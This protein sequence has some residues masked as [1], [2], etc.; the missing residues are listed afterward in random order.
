MITPETQKAI[1]ELVAE[2]A[3]V[4]GQRYIKVFDKDHQNRKRRRRETFIV[5]HG[6]R[7][8][9]YKSKLTKKDRKRIAASKKRNR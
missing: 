9:T 4:A 6:L 3:F 7:S 5:E 8:I 1:D 2:A